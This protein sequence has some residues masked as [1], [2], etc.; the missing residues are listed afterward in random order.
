[1]DVPAKP[2][3]NLSK[4][5]W[6]RI[7]IRM[8]IHIQE[9]IH[10]H[11]LFMAYPRDDIILYYWQKRFHNTAT[12]RKMSV[13]ERFREATMG[14]DD[15]GHRKC[16]TCDRLFSNNIGECWKCNNYTCTKCATERLRE[17][18]PDM[19][20][21]TICPTHAVACS[22][23]IQPF[24]PIGN[25]EHC[26]G[27]QRETNMYVVKWGERDACGTL[28]ILPYGSTRLKREFTIYI[29]VERDRIK[30]QREKDNII[31][32]TTIGT[33]IIYGGGNIA[34]GYSSNA[35]GCTGTI[36]PANVVGYGAYGGGAYGG[37][38]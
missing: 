25:E 19:K 7:I 35:M 33:G 2:G 22:R 17:Y 20:Y 3:I 36:Y 1:M 34:I 23:C 31:Y 24:I 18:F 13:A 12:Q 14:I 16:Y 30:L 27:C 11:P 21:P 9:N 15:N 38:N 10:A 29:Q 28:V 8:P 37:F 6:Y 4:N 32:G 26:F 5:Q